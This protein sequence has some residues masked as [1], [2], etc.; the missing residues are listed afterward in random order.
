MKLITALVQPHRLQKVKD[1][2]FKANVTKMTMNNVH[3]CGQQSGY[4]ETYRGLVHE[5]NLMPKVRIEIAVNENF[6]KP[7]IEAIIKGARTGKIGDGKIFITELAEV[8]RIRTGEK[9]NKAIG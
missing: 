8:V 7:A 1:E 2:L 3:G 5:V 6:V 9:G 4:N